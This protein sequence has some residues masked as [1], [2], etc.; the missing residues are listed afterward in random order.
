MAELPTIRISSNPSVMGD[1]TQNFPVQAQSAT[2]GTTVASQTMVSFVTG[3]SDR[4][5]MAASPQKGPPLPAGGQHLAPGPSSSAALGL[6]TGI[7]SSL[8]HNNELASFQTTSGSDLSTYLLCPVR[9][10]KCYVDCTDQFRCSDQSF[11]CYG[12]VKKGSPVSKQR[13]SNWIVETIILAYKAAGKPLPSGLT[14][15]S[16]RAISSSW[17]AFR[18]VSLADICTAVTWFS[19]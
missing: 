2:C 18:G 4:Q 11:V 13:L 17:A 6:A 19:P 9:A 7:N 15:H 8:E 5:Y 1:V 16:T 12:G 14:C 3:T 10:L